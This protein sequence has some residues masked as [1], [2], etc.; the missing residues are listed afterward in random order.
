MLD[1]SYQVVTIP[2]LLGIPAK[3][4]HLVALAM[5]S[6][7]FRLFALKESPGAFA[8]SYEDEAQRGLDHTIERLTNDKATAFVAISTD[9]AMECD[10]VHEADVDTF[11]ES[12]WLG[13]IVLL[14]PQTSS[15]TSAK[16]DPFN[17][18]TAAG[19]PSENT[20]ETGYSHF[21]LNGM[22][23][24]PSAR[25]L[26]L[27]VRLI[28]AA[29]ENAR[30]IA[31]RS[32]NGIHCTIIV[33]EWNQGAK[34]LYERCGFHVACKETYGKDRIALRMELRQPAQGE[35][36]GCEGAKIIGA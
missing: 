7:K 35:K 9:H 27:G 3:H 15:N 13:F 21:H 36:G 22:F 11:M 5:K 23:V 8:S 34:R 16:I 25:R 29:L 4:S 24:H 31:A 32:E 10:A 19:V 12:E 17:S 1:T 28:K 26:G 30:I 6:R 2:K 20:R 33:D 14:G 18:F